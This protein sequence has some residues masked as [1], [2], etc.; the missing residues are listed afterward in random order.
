MVLATLR[1]G[2]R[3]L[4]LR[5]R[6]G[7]HI[8]MCNVMLH[9]THKSVTN[10]WAAAAAAKRRKSSRLSTPPP[11]SAPPPLSVASRSDLDTLEALLD[12]LEA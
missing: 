10:P 11:S 5:S 3:R 12:T 8:E 7:T 4:R 2:Y 1:P 6:L 9:V